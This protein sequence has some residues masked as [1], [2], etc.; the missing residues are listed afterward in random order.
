M[1]GDR[2]TSADFVRQ[3][4]D[5]TPR[6]QAL[7]DEHLADHDGELLLHVLMA[8]ARRWVISAFYNLQ[9]DTATMAVLH[10]LDEALRDGEANLENAVA[11]SFVEDSCVWHPRMAAFVDAWPRGLRAEAERQQ[12]T[13]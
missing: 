7:V 11:I 8:D 12:S 10:L 3:L 13:T 5:A 2:M 1:A 4:A 6:L 9:D